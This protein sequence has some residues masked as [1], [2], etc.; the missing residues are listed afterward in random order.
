VDGGVPSDEC[1]DGAGGAAG[2]GREMTRLR[3]RLLARRCGP[4]R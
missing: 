4:A 1:G 2:E 3:R